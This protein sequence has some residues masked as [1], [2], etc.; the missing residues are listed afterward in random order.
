MASPIRQGFHPIF[1]RKRG[2]FRPDC[3]KIF[4]FTSSWD[5]FALGGHCMARIRTRVFQS[6]FR[7]SRPMTLGVR[8]VV[9]NEAGKVFMIRHT[10]TP[11]W[12]LPGGGVEKA[13]TC[14]ESLERELLEE[15]GFSADGTAGPGRHL[16]QPSRVSE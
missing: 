13:E 14:L 2:I 8:G 4:A 1:R 16:F 9:E 5:E 3:G 7:L 11:G 12:Y 6:W 10:Y 15:G